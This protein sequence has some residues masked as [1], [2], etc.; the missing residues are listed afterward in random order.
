MGNIGDSTNLLS[1]ESIKQ[2]K[3]CCD[4][5]SKAQGLHHLKL[6]LARFGYLNYQH[7]PNHASTEEENFDD[8]LESAL[9]SYQKY[10]RLDETGTLDEATVTLMV[11]P[12]CGLSDIET[13]RHG[14][15][16]LHSVAHYGVFAGRPRWGKS[17]FTYAFASNYPKNHMPPIVRA[18][19]QW[20][21]ASGYFTFSQINNI[22][23]ADL[24][25]SFEKIDHGDGHSLAGAYAHAFPPRDG[26]IHFN[27]NI[28]FSDG[29]GAVYKVVDLATVALHE[30]G[31]S[32]GLAHSNDKNA[33]M[34][35]YIY[36][37]VVKGLNED[38]IRG[39]K[40][41]YKLE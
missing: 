40:G 1:I 34:Y 41:L 10:Y 19:N 9:K 13:N 6:Y 5:G 27:E 21:S 30:S 20:S 39:I 24:K 38:D 25:V 3:G 16:S 35:A 17:N 29:P 15:K 22:T 4:K 28:T 32:L 7:N 26:R 23:S 2:L 31:H 36:P 8:E 12:R 37:G 14:S 18:L 11:T 33:I